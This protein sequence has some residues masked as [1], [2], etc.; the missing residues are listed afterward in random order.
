MNSDKY[1]MCDVEMYREEWAMQAVI[2]LLL[3]SCECCM[4]R[5][6]SSACL[7]RLSRLGL[8]GGEARRARR[9]H[10]ALTAAHRV[11][12]GR[13]NGRC[14]TPEVAVPQRDA[15]NSGLRQAIEVGALLH[16]AAGH[17]HNVVQCD[18]LEVGRGGGVA[19]RRVG[20]VVQRDNDTILCAVQREV[21][22]SD[23][24]YQAAALPLALHARAV[25]GA[26][27]VEILKQHIVH[28]AAHFTAHTDAV[29]IADAH[30]AESDV[31]TRAACSVC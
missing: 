18:V 1:L 13:P 12:A 21:A 5:A 24:C 2:S 11:V 19:W 14:G 16:A 25:P 10:A 30:A 3:T 31:G 6:S 26:L 22:E 4:Q 17:H 8:T 20:Q 9:Q 15:L 28:S 29:S 7:S 27:L 23:V